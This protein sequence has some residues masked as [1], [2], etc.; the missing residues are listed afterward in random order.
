MTPNQACLNLLEIGSSHLALDGTSS[1]DVTA[2]SSLASGEPKRPLQSAKIERDQEYE[3][4]S[5]SAAGAPDWMAVKQETNQYWTPAQPEER[6]SVPGQVVAPRD[7]APICSP[8][9]HT[10]IEELQTQIN[11]QDKMIAFLQELQQVSYE[12]CLRRVTASLNACSLRSRPFITASETDNRGTGI[13][14]TFPIVGEP[15]VYAEEGI[16]ILNTMKP[17]DIVRSMINRCFAL[18]VLLIGNT[19]NS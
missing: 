16:G 10:I 2:E 3:K 9:L 12:S 14:E 8:Y 18:S 17:P 19:A 13:P 1:Q 4:F 7:G 15:N 5:T 6:T 11:A